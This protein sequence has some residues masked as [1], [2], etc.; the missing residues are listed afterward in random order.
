MTYRVYNVPGTRFELARR[1]QHHHLKVACL[2]V[3]TPGH[4]NWVANLIDLL[5]SRKVFLKPIL[6]KPEIE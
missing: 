6:E 1:F 4:L 2:P 5:I 3:S